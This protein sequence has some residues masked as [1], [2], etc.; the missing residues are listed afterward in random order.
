MIYFL[1]IRVA[2]G[3][4]KLC[5][6]TVG[7]MADVGKA[8]RK[9]IPWKY[10]DVTF[11]SMEEGKEFLKSYSQAG[12]NLARAWKRCRGGEGQTRAIFQCDGH[13]DCPVKLRLNGN[14]GCIKLEGN[15]E[16][17]S[18][19]EKVFDRKNA[20]LSIEEKA[21]VASGNRY[22][23]SASKIFTEFSL[24]A[25]KEKDEDKG[26]K[27]EGGNEAGSEGMLIILCHNHSYNVIMPHI[28]DSRG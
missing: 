17:H 12:L 15:G 10:M 16:V 9:R 20:A 11:S 18:A 6:C 27:R 25:S 22:G 8:P 13:H 4:R 5:S 28:Y 21:E 19:E 3:G 24:S 1:T 2:S 26:R 23:A 7:R 14:A